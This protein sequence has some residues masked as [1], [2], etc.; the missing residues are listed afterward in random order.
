VLSFGCCHLGD[1][2]WVLSFGC[3]HLGV[4][5]W[6][7]SSGYCHLDVVIWGVVIKGVVIWGFVENVQ[8]VTVFTFPNH[9]YKIVII[10]KST[11]RVA[12]TIWITLVCFQLFGLVRVCSRVGPGAASNFLPGA[13][14]T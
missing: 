7:L 9:I 6:V 5:I 2:I 8:T 11:E 12:S 3:C 14:A 10:Q 4:V 1:V 13:G